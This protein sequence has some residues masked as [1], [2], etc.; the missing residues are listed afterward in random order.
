MGR[1][2]NESL[3]KWVTYKIGYLADSGNK[4]L[5]NELLWLSSHFENKLIQ[6]RSLRKR[7]H[8]KISHFKNKVLICT[9]S[10][11]YSRK[12]WARILIS[13]QILEL[14]SIW[15]SKKEGWRLGRCEKVKCFIKATQN[16]TIDVVEH[17]R[18]EKFTWKKTSRRATPKITPFAPL[19][20]LPNYT[21]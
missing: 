11:E 6:N 20:T 13:C 18:C 19:C 12:F 3:Q 10:Q 7:S 21:Y 16:S 2:K 17:G 5:R 4:S 15:I 14:C 8:L 9:F 1:L